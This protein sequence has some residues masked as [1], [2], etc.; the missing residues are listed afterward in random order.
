MQVE[1]ERAQQLESELQQLRAEHQS[2]RSRL[3][4][5]ESSR[6]GAERNLKISKKSNERRKKAIRAVGLQ[7]KRTLNEVK[8]RLRGTRAQVVRD[9]LCLGS[10]KCCLIAAKGDEFTAGFRLAVDQMIYQRLAPVQYNQNAINVELNTDGSP[11]PLVAA[12][13]DLN[14]DLVAT[15]EFWPL[16]QQSVEGE[17]EEEADVIETAPNVGKTVATAE[18]ATTAPAV[19]TLVEHYPS[20]FPRILEAINIRARGSKQFIDRLHLRLREFTGAVATETNPVEN[21]VAEEEDGS[22]PEDNAALNEDKDGSES[23]SDGPGNP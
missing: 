8:D 14:M 2:L 17:P 11:R 15:K 12:D 16:V 23:A 5:A 13:D 10:Y 22:D 4:E 7:F 19:T 9:F 20:W 6:Q 1:K 21:A 18:E 3:D